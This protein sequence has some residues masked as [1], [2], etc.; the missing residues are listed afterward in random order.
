MRTKP[1]RRA[2]G[3]ALALGLVA[4]LHTSAAPLSSSERAWGP[5]E[6][7]AEAIGSWW[8]GLASW[9]SGPTGGELTPPSKEGVIR[10]PHGVP[11][12]PPG[13]GG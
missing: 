2:V 11:G 1:N 13:G 12:A 7:W 5:L 8:D 10:D 9:L 4:A 6:A 3:L